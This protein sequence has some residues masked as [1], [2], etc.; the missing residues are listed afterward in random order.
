MSSV[1][2]LVFPKLSVFDRKAEPVRVAT[3][4]APGFLK[5]P[6]DACVCFEG[7]VFPSQ[8]TATAFWPDGSVKWLLTYFLAD[9]PANR[10]CV[11]T[12]EQGIPGKPEKP[13]RVNRTS[14]GGITIDTGLLTAGLGAPGSP[15]LENIDFGTGSFKKEEFS[16]PW[17]QLKDRRLD[18]PV[19]MEGWTVLENGPVRAALR[20]TGKHSAGACRSLD[21]EFT[22]FAWAGRPE[23]EFEYR[24]IHKEDE[25]FLDIQAMAF[26]VKPETVAEC[27]A[28]A[29]GHE[30]STCLTEN[31]GTM[32]LYSH[33][34][35]GHPYRFED[36]SS[37]KLLIDENYYEYAE[38]AKDSF[39]GT[40]FADWRDTT[41]GISLFV[42][43][44]YQN[45]P[46]AFSLD[47]KELALFI[48]PP[49]KPV[50]I[51]RGSGKRH[52][53][54]M[55]FHRADESLYDLDIRAHQYEY[56]D[57]P[58]LKREA[59]LT[60]GV[61]A[62]YIPA[63]A[64]EPRRE[65]RLKAMSWNTMSTMGMM[66]FGDFW[67]GGEWQNNEYDQVHW[68]LVQYARTGDRVMFDKMLVY[69][70]HQL[71]VDFCHYDPE[72][73][74]RQG[75]AVEHSP[76]HANGNVAVCHQWTEGLI[77][78]YHQTGDVRALDAA[79]SIAKNQTALLEAHVFSNPRYGAPRQ[80]GWA[81]RSLA[82]VYGETGDTSLLDPCEKIV[83]RFITWQEEYGAWLGFYTTHTQVRVPFMQS[84]A[85]RALAYYEQLKPDERVRKLV[86][87]EINDI[88]DNGIDPVS[89]RLYYKEVPYTRVDSLLGHVFE[90]F[91][92]GY[93][94]SGDISY[95]TRVKEMF[96]SFMEETVPH[97]TSPRNF[98]EC[99]P[100][101]ASYLKALEKAGL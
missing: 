75:G 69:G 56:P 94:Y 25:P 23:L 91:V 10:G 32:T 57:R 87:H 88:L 1:I 28:H 16:G 19:G 53:F 72:R 64:P 54:M 90:C 43:Q 11:Y 46:K 13:V 101:P 31:D 44:A 4:H 5:N 82:S 15:V 51:Y 55:R 37:L 20:T 22:V 34:F 80:M 2:D 98:A 42:Y 89:G 30:G 96:D 35:D 52:H 12:L 18:L 67:D 97:I 36:S 40:L 100:G 61:F 77:D 70:E 76:E 92:I 17:V 59:Y 14:A 66:N 7:A 48:V 50:R 29:R 9:L 8:S 33:G 41:R 21:Y 93:R 86:L 74:F 85:I 39:T 68:F 63:K 83:R 47:K 79:K 49:E 24:F 78:F 27:V 26:Q 3:P 95:L 73:T 60:A 84:V 62:D 58:F 99:F 45:F 71:D 81:L 65:W 38:G 6:A